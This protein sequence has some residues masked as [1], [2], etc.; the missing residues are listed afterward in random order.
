MLLLLGQEHFIFS[1][2]EENMLNI[3]IGLHFTEF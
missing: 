2:K 3:I 1:R